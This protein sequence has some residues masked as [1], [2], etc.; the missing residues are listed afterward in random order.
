MSNDEYMWISIW[1]C[2]QKTIN[3]VHQNVQSMFHVTEIFL[4]VFK[5]RPSCGHWCAYNSGGRH[6]P[7]LMCTPRDTPC[8]KSL[9]SAENRS[10]RTFPLHVTRGASPQSSWRTICETT[11]CHSLVTFVGLVPSTSKW[12]HTTLI[13]ALKYIMPLLKEFVFCF[14]YAEEAWGSRQKKTNILNKGDLTLLCI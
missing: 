2:H 8:D 6:M 1:Y 4:S 9:F 12:Q 10:S 14:F 3:A 11:R 13:L 5:P 7:A